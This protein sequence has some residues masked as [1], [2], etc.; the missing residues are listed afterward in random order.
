MHVIIS[1]EL[2]AS[3]VNSFNIIL[4]ELLNT[5]TVIEDTTMLIEYKIIKIHRI[6]RNFAFKKT[7]LR[8]NILT[9]ITVKKI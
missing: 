5:N 6:E 3:P 1:I 9:R 8:N 4:F 2:I 7:N